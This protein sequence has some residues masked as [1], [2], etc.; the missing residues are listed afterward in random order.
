M[1]RA[2]GIIAA[3]HRQEQSGVLRPVADTVILDYAK[4][5]GEPTSA[6][7]VK[8]IVI[9]IHLHGAPRLRT[10]DLLSLDDGTL[11]EVVAAPEPL[12]EARAA[13]VAALARLAWHLGDRHIAVQ[14]LPNRIRARRDDAV[15]AL[16]AALGAKVTSIDAPFEPEGGAYAPAAARDQ[17]H[18]HHHGHDHDHAHCGHDHS[19]DHQHGHG[20]AHHDAH[21]HGHRHD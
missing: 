1:P 15:E 9:D 21:A 10:D 11:V 4:R 19:H 7:S 3:D 14:L 2:T 8:G 5:S 6:T 12:I 13:D 18:D 20:H 16:L 17:A